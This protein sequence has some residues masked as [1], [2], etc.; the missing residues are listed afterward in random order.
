MPSIS[1]VSLDS[2]PFDANKP[3][4]PIRIL[5]IDDEV[6]IQPIDGDEFIDNDVNSLRD[7]EPIL[8]AQIEEGMVLSIIEDLRKKEERRKQIADK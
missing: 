4:D 2:D 3:P 1:S 5:P 6:E 8:W 7:A